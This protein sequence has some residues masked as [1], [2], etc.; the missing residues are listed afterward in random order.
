MTGQHGEEIRRVF[1]QCCISPVYANSFF[2]F[3]YQ[4]TVKYCLNTWLFVVSA[5]S[6]ARDLPSSFV[7]RIYSGAPYGVVVCNVTTHLF[8]EGRLPRSDRHRVALTGSD[9][10]PFQ[11]TGGGELL[12]VGEYPVLSGQIGDEYAVNITSLDDGE[13]T[14]VVARTVQLRLL[15]S[16]ENRSPPR[17]IRKS[18]ALIEGDDRS[19]FAD[20]YRYSA[21]GTPLRMRQT[22]SVSDDDVDDYN[23]AV[24]FSAHF[25]GG[26]RWQR[27]RSPNY[28]AKYLGIDPVTGELS[29][30]QVLR[31][32]LADVMRVSIV[33]ANS[34]ASPPL[35]S[36][37]ALTVYVCDVPGE[38]SV[39]DSVDQFCNASL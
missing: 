34:V 38:T 15:V 4:T 13:T 25:R 30:G 31:A 2:F 10:A 14:H 6:S 24:T 9:A 32:A 28:D 22:I 35:T 17:F 23:R 8:P 7:V 33:A 11:I 20:A 19:Y 26:R 18:P 27:R 37:I 29:T 3:L 36:S 16:R 39:S 1:F 5:T 12:A 21:D